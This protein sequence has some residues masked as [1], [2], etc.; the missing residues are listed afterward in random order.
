M[1]R[2]EAGF[3][4]IFLLGKIKGWHLYNFIALFIVISLVQG[5]GKSEVHH[6]IVTQLLLNIETG[7]ITVFLKIFNIWIIVA[8][9]KHTEFMR[10]WLVF[11]PLMNW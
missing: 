1:V 2:E 6:S 3:L 10:T 5:M 9:D 8:P 4:L 11:Q 7:H